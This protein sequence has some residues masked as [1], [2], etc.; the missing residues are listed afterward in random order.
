LHIS[1]TLSN[2]VQSH[3][4]KTALVVDGSP[5]NYRD[6]DDRSNGLARALVGLGIA[7]GDRVTL[8]GPNSWQWIVAYYAIAKVGAVGNPINVMLT[9]EEVTYVLRDCGA[10][11][12]VASADNGG[13]VLDA[14]PPVAH[15][16]LWDGPPGPGALE[17]E[18]LIDDHAGPFAV[19]DCAADEDIFGVVRDGVP[20]TRI[21][22]FGGM[23]AN[24][25]IWRVVTAIRADSRC[26]DPDGQA[27]DSR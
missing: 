8:Y 5:L 12:L 11:V 14:A 22:G 6:L 27:P 2:A 10:R 13:P 20:D 24:D 18:T 15:A 7:P 3:A 4:D 1:K 21:Q 9:P 17:L 26:D 19:V 16:L 25:D 23:L